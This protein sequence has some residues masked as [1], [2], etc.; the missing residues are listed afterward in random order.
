M[1]APMNYTAGIFRHFAEAKQLA[2]SLGE[3]NIASKIESISGATHIVFVRRSQGA[4][5]VTIGKARSGGA[6]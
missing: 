6:A 4:R 2:A 1:S 5:A 3:E